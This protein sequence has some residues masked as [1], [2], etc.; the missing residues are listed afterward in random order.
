MPVTAGWMAWSASHSASADPAMANDPRM[1]GYLTRALSSE[2]AAVQQYL[3][4]ASLTAMWQLGTPSSR[5]RRDAE[6]ELGHAQRLIE[7]MLVLGIPSNGTQLP[8]IRLGRSLEEMLLI[9]REL[10]IEVIRLYEEAANYCARVRAAETQTL[11]ADLLQEELGHL[12]DL[13]GMLT[14]M[15]QGATS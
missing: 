12:R 3:T 2:M 13:D 14:G 10:E 8:P 5:F 4:Q 1:M 7:R 11:F 9:D 6:E 15:H